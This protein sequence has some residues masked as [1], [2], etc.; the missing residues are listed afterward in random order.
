MQNLH[1]EN[2]ILSKLT[3]MLDNTSKQKMEKDIE[4][5]DVMNALKKTEKQ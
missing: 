2:D 5:V 4:M 3:N 1:E